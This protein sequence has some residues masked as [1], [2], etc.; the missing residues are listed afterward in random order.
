MGLSQTSVSLYE[1]VI[2]ACGVI[3]TPFTVMPYDN[4][5]DNF[6]LKKDC[7]SLLKESISIAHHT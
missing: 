7:L 1:V 4:D 5:N 2:T 3:T 6:N